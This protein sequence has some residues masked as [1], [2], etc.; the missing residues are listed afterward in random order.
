[1]IRKGDKVKIKPEY[2]D[3]GDSEIEFIAIENEDGGRVKIQARLGLTYNPVQVVRTEM[4][5][6]AS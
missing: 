2:Q 6:C 3:I 1:M 5:Q 4:I